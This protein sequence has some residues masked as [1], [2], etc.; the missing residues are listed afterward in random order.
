MEKHSH[1]HRTF[2]ALSFQSL[3]RRQE[4]AFHASTDTDDN[5]DEES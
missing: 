2:A 4:K 1:I 3:L 5:D